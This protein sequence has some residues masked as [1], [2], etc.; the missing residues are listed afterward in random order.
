MVVCKFGGTSLATAEQIRK[1]ADIIAMDAE[2]RFIVVSAPGKRFKDDVKVTDLLYTCY[3]KAQAGESFSAEF[4]DI[5]GRFHEI[6]E[7]LGIDFEPVKEALDVVERDLQA[8]ASEDYAASRGEFLCG[9]MV[10]EYLGYMI[11]DPANVLILDKRGLVDSQS[12]ERLAAAVSPEGSY[13][14]PGFYGALKD[15]SVKTFSRG[16]SDISGAAA[17][18]AVHALRYENWTDVSGILMADPRIVDNPEEISEITYQEIRELASI[19]AGVFHEEAIAPVR[20]AG[21]PIQIKNTNDPKAQGTI[22]EQE[23][24]LADKPVIGISGKNNYSRLYIKKN[25]LNRYPDYQLQIMTILKVQGIQPE[26][27]S[28]GFDSISY[29]FPSSL[30]KDRDALIRRITT[31]LHPDEICTDQEVG[32]IGIVGEGMYDKPGVLSI[33]G[34]ALALEGIS[35]RYVNYGGSIISCI[36]GV[37]AD[38]FEKAI[39]VCVRAIKEWDTAAE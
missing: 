34:A 28:V 2:R 33:I 4:T 26:F 30:I 8:G 25:L 13:V 36:I 12:Y 32:M 24:D 39:Q 29:Y 35:V 21:I 20:E 38:V 16:G 31:E 37:D 17:A 18:R 27:T 22:I 23:R 5:T 6:S 3:R 11:I 10:S 1:A 14:M 7:G 9:M 19:G 15:G